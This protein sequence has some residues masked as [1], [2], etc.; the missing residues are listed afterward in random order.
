[1]TQPSVEKAVADDRDVF[2]Y[3]RLRYHPDV[4]VFFASELWRTLTAAERQSFA[5]EM[6]PPPSETDTSASDLLAEIERLVTLPARTPMSA[7]GH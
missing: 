1:M 5:A 6:P 3:W 7:T 2:N 4:S